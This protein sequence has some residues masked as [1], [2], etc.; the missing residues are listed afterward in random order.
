M[1]VRR[2]VLG[3]SNEHARIEDACW[4]K[5]VLG[6]RERRCKRIWTLL[7]IP[8]PVVTSDRMMVGD[9]SSVLAEHILG[10]RV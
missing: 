9:A 1:T 5:C 10:E 6:S 4:V 3:L 8:G 2:T 7:V